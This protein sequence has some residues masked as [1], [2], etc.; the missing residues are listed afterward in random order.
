[1]EGVTE[2]HSRT[3][4]F[5]SVVHHRQ[6]NAAPTLKQPTIFRTAGSTILGMSTRSSKALPKGTG[7]RISNAVRI[8]R[9]EPFCFLVPLVEFVSWKTWSSITAQNVELQLG[10]PSAGARP[11]ALYTRREATAGPRQE[12]P[13]RTRR[14]TRDCCRCF[15]SRGRAMLIALR[16]SGTAEEHSV[17]ERAPSSN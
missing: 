1:M 16:K 15:G 10:R 4:R 8:P 14:A 17:V 3:G 12:A 6:H 13:A 7:S 2:R 9:R 11:D 5:D